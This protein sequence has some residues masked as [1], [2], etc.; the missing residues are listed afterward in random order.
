LQIE[1]NAEARRFDISLQSSSTKPLCV[2]IHNWPNTLGE[3]HY[4]ADHVFAEISGDRYSIR[5]QNFGYCVGNQ[6]SHRIEPGAILSGFVSYAEFP[7]APL[8]SASSPRLIFPLPVQ[9]CARGEGT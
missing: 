9:Y 5:D 4:S 8:G 7:G 3:M 2:S 6:C 1:A